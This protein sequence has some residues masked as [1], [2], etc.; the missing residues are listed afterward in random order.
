[1]KKIYTLLIV[2]C[3]AISANAQFLMKSESHILKVGDEHYFNISN[4]VDAGVNGAARVW[5]FSKLETS[6]QLTSY[7]YDITKSSNSIDIP[8]ANTILEEFGVKFFFKSTENIM[9]QYGTVTGNTITKYDKPFVK[10]VFPFEYGDIY[11]GDFSG[12]IEGPTF[13]QPIEGTYTLEAD[14][15][16]TLIIPTGIYRNVIRIKTYKEEHSKGSTCNCAVVSYKWYSKDIRYP[17]LTIIQSQNSNGTNTI[18]TAYYSKVKLN[19]IVE[20]EIP[21]LENINATIY[22]NPFSESFKIDY[23]IQKDSPVEIVIYDNS[24]RKITSIQKQKQSA[25]YYTET[26]TKEQLGTQQGLFHIRITAG[27]ET[28][29]RTVI[30]GGE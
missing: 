2:S 6:S 15:Y 4:N 24:G 14:A 17:L 5:D 30:R 19:E 3:I 20:K 16:G 22:P 29:S 7:M 26:F 8:E 21:I 9:E 10:M 12:V 13:K 23:Y 18:R 1:M 28:I 27:D 11:T 25:G